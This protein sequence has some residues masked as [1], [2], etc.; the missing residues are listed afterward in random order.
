MAYYQKPEFVINYSLRGI[1]EIKKY[2]TAL[3]VWDR[4]NFI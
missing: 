1:N 2:K 4:R 3:N